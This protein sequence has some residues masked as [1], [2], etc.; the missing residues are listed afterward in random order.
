[1]N[2]AEGSSPDRAPSPTPRTLYITNELP[3]FPGQ[4]G[5]MTQKVRYLATRQFTG[6]VGPRYP[7]QPADVLQDLRDMVD[8]S[9]WWPEPPASGDFLVVPDLWT[10]RSRW[11]KSLPK[12]IKHW[13]WRRLT[14]LSRY[15]DDAL[16]WRVLITQLA[17]KML[18]A[19]GAE[20]WNSVLLSQSTSVVWFP[21]LPAS[22]ARCIYFHDI[23]S[24]Y[25]RRSTFRPTRGNLRRIFV[26]E[27]LAS[28]QADAMAVVSELD[29]RRAEKFL[30]PSCPNAVSPISL[31]LDY[32]A[33]QPAKAA[34]DPVVLFTGHLSHPPNIDA[35]LY[36][37]T[38]IWPRVLAAM[39]R[40]RF[41]IVGIQPA[42]AIIDAIGRSRQ[43]ELFP[44][45][46]DIRPYFHA[47]GVYVVPMRFGGGVRQKILEAWAVGVP[48]VTT[49]MGAEGIDAED[50][51]HC[52]LRDDPGQFADQ[53]CALLR[54]PAP[55]SLLQAAR[56]FVETH[57][58]FL[59]ACPSLTDQVNV[60]IKRRNQSPPRV[61]YDLRGRQPGQTSEVAQTADE[62]V[63]ELASFDR[64]GEYRFFGPRRVCR[65]LRLP[66]E[67]RR[68]VV[69]TDG[70][71]A[72]WVNWRNA[73]THELATDLA[74][75]S[76]TSPELSALE[77]YTRLDFTVVHGLAGFVSPDLRRFPAVVTV[78]DL[79]HLHR[80]E[81]FAPTE[82]SQREK[83]QRESCQLASH[84]ICASEFTRDDIHRHYG[85]PREKMTT[86]W[87]LTPHLAEAPLAGPLTQRLLRRMGVKP[88]F[89]F[90]DAEPLPHKNHRGLLEA[91]RMAGASLPEGY[92]LV[93][94]GAP[95][96]PDHP[97]AALLHDSQ[98]HQRVISLG[99]RSPLEIAALYRGAEALVFPSLFEGSA[100]P[101]LEAMQQSCPIVCGQHTSLPEFAG[102][103]ALFAD[104][105]SPPALAEAIL[106][107]TRDESLRTQLRLR[108]TANLR[109]Y[110]RRSLA[111]KTRAI[112][113]SVHAQ[114][115][116]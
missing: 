111:E 29:R 91:M 52:W 23:R 14:N 33:F 58:S 70:L 22:L 93:L 3:Y 110:H 98:L 31:D 50:G 39:P 74:L 115:F 88:P 4:G 53:V 9:Y 20:R 101:L 13:L 103:G 69:C 55:V 104:V 113:A 80:P 62:L 94:T 8:R 116:T 37:L 75:P 95:L 18:E 112:Y 27:H 48:V 84:V 45:V 11:L 44:H 40:A 85:V 15:S 65:N 89:L 34:A 92:T 105:A 5:H 7:Q 67:F 30:H 54:T 96:T 63:H 49:T 64:T 71:Q 32:F 35:A 25:L 12:G 97:A 57:H 56:T 90:Y 51:V 73:A 102:E 59:A 68:K 81:D 16:P 21:F 26:E 43:V 46:P 66:G 19:L 114:H 99:Q 76:L 77:W 41:Q 60:A 36:F 82:L 78:H 100:R 10:Q 17:P 72:R 87:P 108:G 106:L 28:H 42:P 83:D 107:I 79:R 38:E 2:P 47:A 109:R 24:D 1:M 61:L 86:L 6:V